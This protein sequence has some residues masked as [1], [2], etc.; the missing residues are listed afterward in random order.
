MPWRR[1]V[2]WI[3]GLTLAT[4]VFELGLAAITSGIL[5]GLGDEQDWASLAWL[6]GSVAG[7]TIWSYW[8]VHRTQRADAARFPESPATSDLTSVEAGNKRRRRWRTSAVSTGSALLPILGFLLLFPACSSAD[9]VIAAYV[10]QA[11][12][13]EVTAVV[14]GY[15]VRGDSGR[16]RIPYTY[17]SLRRLDG[18]PIPGEFSGPERKWPIGHQ[19]V[20]V[21]SPGG[22]VNPRV[23]EAL[24]PTRPLMIFGVSLA[25]QAAIYSFCVCVFFARSPRERRQARL[26]YEYAPVIRQR[27]RDRA[28]RRYRAMALR[29]F[30]PTLSAFGL[31]DKHSSSD[32]EEPPASAPRPPWESPGAQALLDEYRL[33]KA[34]G[35]AQIEWCTICGC[36]HD[37]R[38]PQPCAQTAAPASDSTGATARASDP[39]WTSTDLQQLVEETRARLVAERVAERPQIALCPACGSFHDLRGPQPCAKSTAAE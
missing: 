38:G 20:V 15:Q 4:A 33:R 13:R 16:Y 1:V 36:L 35:P 3:G 37:L 14:T 23:P 8:I 28:R 24:D 21:E 10:L 34:L 19:L 27:A 17:Y 7:L 5:V 26:Q 31:R 6:L 12:G 29:L 9:D 32:P 25:A 39:A 30:G 11:E 2:S 18:S 22:L